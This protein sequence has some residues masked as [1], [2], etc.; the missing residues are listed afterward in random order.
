M[1]TESEVK[2]DVGKDV[3]EYQEVG[4]ATAASPDSLQ[5]TA[6]E[7]SVLSPFERLAFRLVRR[8][9]CG[10]WKRFWT[11]CQRI[12]GAGWIHISTY[13]IMNVYG[14]ENVEAV[15]HE[16]PILLV[17]NHRSFFDMYAVSTV[18]FRNTKWRKQLFFPV[19]GRFFY[20][21][22]IGVFVN[23]VMGWFSMFPP[24]FATGDH[25]IP[26]KRLFD[27]FSFRVLVE[28][29]RTGAG[30]IIGFHPE[31]TR[32]K[33]ED[34][35]SFLRAQPGV[36]KL[37][38]E[39]KPQVIPVFIAGLCNDLPKQI[40]RNWNREEVIRIYFGPQLDLSEE[41]KKPDRLRTH[42]EIAD[43]LMAKIAELGERDRL[44]ME[45]R[46]I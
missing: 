6:E 22:P 30:N 32:N 39:A 25:P 14:L 5:P 23:L 42:K 10:A 3:S 1:R 12:F 31:G 4:L 41:L 43:F 16:R 9:N 29:A 45:P 8:M 40:A 24:F 19:R 18:L 27:K 44:A 28:L 17:A 15:S 21:S 37:I 20:Q 35:Y 13:N 38:M 36:G 2:L 26:E 46:K 34:P 7:L 33:S 11:F